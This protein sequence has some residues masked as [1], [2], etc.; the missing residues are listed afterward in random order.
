MMLALP[1]QKLKEEFGR[2]LRKGSDF[3]AMY[4]ADSETFGRLPKILCKIDLIR[5]IAQFS[6]DYIFEVMPQQANQWDL[7]IYGKSY[8]N[9][10][11]I[12]ALG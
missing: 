11:Q 3:P 6:Q 10:D 4:M 5:A 12:M 7:S 9:P 8:I 1:S 2:Y